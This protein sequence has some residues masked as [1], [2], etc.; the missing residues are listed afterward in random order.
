MSALTSLVAACDALSSDSRYAKKTR[1]LAVKWDDEIVKATALTHDGAV[2][3]PS[4]A[5][6]S[7]A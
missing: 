6:K 7:A 3:H 2:I 1:A 5:A 4:F